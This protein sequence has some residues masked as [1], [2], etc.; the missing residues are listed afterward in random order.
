MALKHIELTAVARPESVKSAGQAF[1]RGSFKATW[2]VEFAKSF[3]K[4]STKL[5]KRR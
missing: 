5:N 2:R 4:K 1:S 3:W